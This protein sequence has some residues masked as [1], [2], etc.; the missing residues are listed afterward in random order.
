[1]GFIK[2]LVDSIGEYVALVSI[3][4]GYFRLD[5]EFTNVTSTIENSL[6]YLHNF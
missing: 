3:S 6:Y 5:C 4:D 2:H 1:M